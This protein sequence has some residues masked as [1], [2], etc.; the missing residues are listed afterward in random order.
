MRPEQGQELFCKQQQTLICDVNWTG[1]FFLPKR[2]SVCT[3]MM[4][5]GCGQSLTSGKQLRRMPKLQKDFFPSL[6]LF[7]LKVCSCDRNFFFHL[8][9]W[10]LMLFFFQV[11]KS[12]A[13][14]LLNT[15]APVK[16]SEYSL[17][18]L[19]PKPPTARC[20]LFLSIQCAFDKKT[21]K[22]PCKRQKC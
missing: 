2:D 5:F 19:D 11:T 12:M 20:T 16:N 8:L 1:S 9:D 3:G 4:G 22:S 7:F 17:C 10:I 6:S 21:G 13:E 14:S 15:E 18:G